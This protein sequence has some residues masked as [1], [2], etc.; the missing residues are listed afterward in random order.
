MSTYAHK[1]LCEDLIGLMADAERI[2]PN[3]P[4][5]KKSYVLMEL[6][7]DLGN[8]LYERYLPVLEPMIDLLKQIAKHR[9]KV[10]EILLT[11]NKKKGFFSKLCMKATS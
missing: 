9:S 7:A 6:R 8:M 11:K 2:F 1:F 5:Q 10:F 4:M 3:S